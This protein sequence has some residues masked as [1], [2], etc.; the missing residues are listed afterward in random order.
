[1][2]VIVQ[3]PDGLYSHRVCLAIEP[4]AGKGWEPPGPHLGL[5]DSAET[6]E[7]EAAGR[8]V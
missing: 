6:A 2:V 3:R 4:R 5:Y 1:M 7:L 8:E